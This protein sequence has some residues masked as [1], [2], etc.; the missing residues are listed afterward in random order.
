MDERDQPVVQAAARL[1]VDQLDA[2]CRQLVE[3]GRQV[4]DEVGDVVDA[5]AACVEE[6]ADWRVV[7]DRR[8][9]LDPALAGPQRG[10]V[11]VLLGH[12]RHLAAGESQRAVLLD[13]NRDVANN[14][15]EV[16]DRARGDACGLDV[17]W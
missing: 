11:G 4:V 5:G 9:D 6:S 15:A 3:R 17:V 12:P 1:T 2:G 7:L 8:E 14:D 16:M 10:D 13:G